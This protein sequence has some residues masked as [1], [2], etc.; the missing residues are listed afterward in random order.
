M[1]DRKVVVFAV[2]LILISMI[3]FNFD[4]ITGQVTSSDYVSSISVN[5]QSIVSGGVISV[6]VNPGREGINQKLVFYFAD[7]GLRIANMDI[8]VCRSYKCFE[9]V[10]VNQR[11]YLDNF[12][13]FDEEVQ[14]YVEGYDRYKEQPIRVYFTVSPIYLTD[15]PRIR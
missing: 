7:T 12:D 2:L 14:V 1:D 10:T 3:S 8:N 13:D 4:K 6:T 15:G 11:F 9:E 5:P